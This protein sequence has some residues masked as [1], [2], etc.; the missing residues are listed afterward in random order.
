MSIVSFDSTMW[1]WPNLN[2]KVDIVSNV[3][4]SNLNRLMQHFLEQ[5]TLFGMNLLFRLNKDWDCKEKQFMEITTNLFLL[6][7]FL[8]CDDHNLPLIIYHYTTSIKR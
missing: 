5:I 8:F 7:V 4:H 1:S 2:H 6:V 3:N